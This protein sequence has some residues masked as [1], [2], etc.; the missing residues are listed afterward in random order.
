[1]SP[2]IHHL[3][4]PPSTMVDLEADVSAFWP[5]QPTLPP[6]MPQETI[7]H[8]QLMKLKTQCLKIPTIQPLLAP[9]SPLC[10]D[11]YSSTPLARQPSLFPIPPSMLSLSSLTTHLSSPS[12]LHNI[13]VKFTPDVSTQHIRW[14]NDP[15]T[16]CQPPAALPQWPPTITIPLEQPP[17]HRLP[18][19]NMQSPWTMM[20][21]N[22]LTPTPP[23]TSIPITPYHM[24][25][26]KT[27]KNIATSL[28]TTAINHHTTHT[29]NHLH[30]L[31]LPFQ[32]LLNCSY[33]VET[34][35]LKTMT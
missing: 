6:Y 22:I 26:T 27:T 25:M 8:P 17:D 32:P 23:L 7:Q 15:T 9:G 1:M 3:P 21:S 19:N 33:P 20:A 34:L 18:S 2:Y 35:T 24:I 14:Q 12:P 13:S 11:Q 5:P 29:S 16:T 31:S 28:S 4:I 30:H 10:V